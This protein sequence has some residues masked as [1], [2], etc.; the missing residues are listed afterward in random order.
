MSD[1]LVKACENFFESWFGPAIGAPEALERINARRE[2]SKKEF[3]DVLCRFVKA[4]QSIRNEGLPVSLE[5]CAK[6]IHQTRWERDW[7]SETSASHKEE[8]REYAKAVLEEAGVSY[9]S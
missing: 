7:Y 6:A 9:G 4:W 1:E 5:K 2:K 3:A 8:L